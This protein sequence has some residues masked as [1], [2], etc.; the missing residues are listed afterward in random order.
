METLIDKG[1]EYKYTSLQYVDAD[2]M[3]NAKILIDEDMYI[4]LYEELE[5]KIKLSWAAES[6]E[7]FFKG[8][9]KAQGLIFDSGVT[10]KKI[11]MEFIPE[12]FIEELKKLE[13]NIVAEFVDFWNED[14]LNLL[15]NQCG[16]FNIRRLKD[17]ENNI[18]AQITK[19]CMGYSR[20]FIGEDEEWIEEW[21]NSDNSCI[22]VAEKQGEIIGISC[23]NLYGFESSKGIILWI[24][25][26]AVLPSYQ[27]QGVGSELLTY[28][29]K[30]GKE[31]GAKRSF[32]ACDI[33]NYRGINLYERLGYVRTDGRGQ[34]NMEK[35]L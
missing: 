15:D 7:D 17:N 27:G 35:I 10:Q 31:N 14:I 34:I 16:T 9:E 6:K 11:Y 29:I 30:W 4:F 32:L 23:I 1:R 3:K 13:F 19:S 5:D 20:G 18:A 24:R 33:E 12:G 2:D 22:F 21:N 25:E 28:S 8:L 26:I